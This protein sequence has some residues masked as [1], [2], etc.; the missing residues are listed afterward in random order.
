MAIDQLALNSQHM[1]VHALLCLH[2]SVPVSL[3][4]CTHSAA[5]CDMHSI[6]PL[7]KMYLLRRTTQAT[8]SQL[9]IRHVA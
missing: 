1:L 9:T 7:C 5:A 8:A 3:H 2:M 6:C 4:S